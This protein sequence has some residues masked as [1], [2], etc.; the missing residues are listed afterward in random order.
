MQIEIQPWLCHTL[1]PDDNCARYDR[2]SEIYKRLKQDKASV[3]RLLLLSFEGVPAA[4]YLSPSSVRY[5]RELLEFAHWQP[6][7]LPT[8]GR[9]FP[10]TEL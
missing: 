9:F 10:L 7:L 6:C 2:I 8:P 4:L 3:V 5:C 1:E